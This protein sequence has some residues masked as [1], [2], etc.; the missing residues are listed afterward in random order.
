M[1]FLAFSWT[2]DLLA[3][4]DFLGTT[5]LMYFNFLL[6]SNV[7]IVQISTKVN[8][9][10]LQPLPGLTS[11]TWPSCKAYFLVV[12]SYMRF[13]LYKIIDWLELRKRHCT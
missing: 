3:S 13:F 2:L 9:A 12:L 8:F 5:F 10:A 7:D 4:E 11:N 1:T 6:S